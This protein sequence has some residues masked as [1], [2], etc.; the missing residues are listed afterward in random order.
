MRD[1]LTA[2]WF[3]IGSWTWTFL[4]LVWA[5]VV[6][7]LGILPEDDPFVSWL[8]FLAPFFAVLASIIVTRSPGNAIAWLL[9]TVATGIS[10]GAV[11]LM[12]IPEVAPDQVPVWL[13]LTLTFEGVSWM[14][15]I[16]PILLVP[17]LFPTGRFLSPRWRWAGWLTAA[18]VLTLLGI[19]ALQETIGPSNEQWTTKSPVGVVPNAFF[20]DYLSVPW[21]LGLLA[22]A[23]GGVVSLILRFR[24]SNHEE[25]AQIKWVLY[26]VVVFGVTYA[27][28]VLPN[29]VVFVEEGSDSLVAALFWGFFGLSFALI[30]V[31]IV[32][33]ITRYKLYAIDRIFSRTVSY[34]LVVG[35]LGSV[36]FGVLYLLGTVLPFESDLA[37]A[38]STLVVVGLFNPVRGR[39]QGFVDRR[40]DRSRYNAVA[41]VRAFVGRLGGPMDEQRLALELG[42]VLDTTMRPE[43]LGVWIREA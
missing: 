10:L 20:D 34:S 21:S 1:R 36:Y 3:T 38:A 41:V 7:F 13:L 24:R 11:A 9:G 23:L 12:V 17:F 28:S 6:Y 2:G 43:T 18:M 14:F 42:D 39:V 40:F 22:L 32:V 4:I 19:G 15:F 29:D 33:A 5:L 8:N 31:S 25:R 35:F 27:A 37:V 16:F 26:A 30:P